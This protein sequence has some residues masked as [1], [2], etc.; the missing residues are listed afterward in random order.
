MKQADIDASHEYLYICQFMTVL[1]VYQIC[2]EMLKKG[3]GALHLIIINRYCYKGCAAL[4]LR[5]LL[6]I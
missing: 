5:T 3:F 2:I 4:P 6:I 1:L